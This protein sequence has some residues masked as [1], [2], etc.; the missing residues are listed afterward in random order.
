MHELYVEPTRQH[1]RVV[2]SNQGSIE[3]ALEPIVDA[4][5]QLGVSV[6]G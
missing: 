3:T 1:A 2:L 4:L 6:D 5:R